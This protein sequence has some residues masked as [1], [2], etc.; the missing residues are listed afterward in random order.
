M[1]LPVGW[2]K[3]LADLEATDHGDGRP[4]ITGE[5]FAWAREYERRLLRPWARF[6]RDGEVYESVEAVPV[7]FVTHWSAPFTG[8]GEGVLPK[9]TRIRVQV[10]DAE[11]IGVH[12][13]AENAADIEDQL[14]GEQDRRSPTYG[15]Y[16]LSISTEDLNRHFRLV[17]S[18]A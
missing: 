14:V 16:S 9:G 2:N 4:C 12:A 17:Q 15:G 7:S 3:R 6:P 5:E 13:D 18:A 8:G 10:L 1:E 11:P